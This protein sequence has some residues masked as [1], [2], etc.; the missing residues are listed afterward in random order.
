MLFITLNYFDNIL[1]WIYI[2]LIFCGFK[3]E[4]EPIENRT[5]VLKT[6]TD[7]MVWL[8]VRF[9]PRTTPIRTML[10]PSVCIVYVVAEGE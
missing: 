8:R 6:E 4:T 7:P 3:T 2:F 9:Y 10:S 5:E 1:N